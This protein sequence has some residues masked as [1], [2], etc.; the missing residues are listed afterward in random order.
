MP[1]SP[2]ALSPLVTGPDT[3]VPGENGASDLSLDGSCGRNGWTNVFL[4]GLSAFLSIPL[5][6][7][8]FSVCLR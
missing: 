3:D 2:A 6:A 1:G 5:S 8:G 4:A 7:P